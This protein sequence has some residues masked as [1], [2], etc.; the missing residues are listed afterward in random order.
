MDSIFTARG[1]FSGGLLEEVGIGLFFFM[2]RYVYMEIWIN[3]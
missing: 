3:G 2:V 1:L